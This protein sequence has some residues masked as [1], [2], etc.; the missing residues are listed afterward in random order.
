MAFTY[1]FYNS[2][3]GD[4]RYNAEQVSMLF[5]GL[6]LDGVY[7]NFKNSLMVRAGSSDNEILVQPGRAWFEHTWCYNDSDYPIILDSADIYQ[8]RIDA[9][10]IDVSGESG[11][12]VNQLTFVKGTP[13]SDP[14]PPE[15]INDPDNTHY[16]F[17]LAYVR[18]PKEKN[19]IL[20]EYIENKVGTSECP[21]V[22]GILDSTSIDDLLLQWKNRLDN[23]I[24][25]YEEE[26]EE[27]TEDEKTQFANLY[28][29]FQNQLNSFLDSASID[30]SSFMSEVKDLMDGDTALN[31]QKQ[32]MEIRET[33]FERY[34]DLF[35][36][37]TIIDEIQDEIVVT[38]DDG[39]MTTTF[40]KNGND[41]SK[42]I[43]LIALNNENFNYKKTVSITRTSNGFQID[44]SYMRVGK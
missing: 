27:W 7:A 2:L 21:F 42:V 3:N 18:R 28:E 20:Q 5:D 12:R 32:I 38:N 29:E 36:T 14:Q 13:S 11:D 9:I 4:R 37:T 23:L 40:E 25:K 10:I 16:Q 44:T 8:D 1:G 24:D 33:E 43:T 30:F 15:M 26:A 41:I 31:L 19:Q 6:I 39:V 17:P 34:Y 22:T 35:D